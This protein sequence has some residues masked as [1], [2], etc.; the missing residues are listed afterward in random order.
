[1]N[2]LGEYYSKEN[3]WVFYIDEKPVLEYYLKDVVIPIVDYFVMEKEGRTLDEHTPEEQEALL[4]WFANQVWCSEKFGNKM[5]EWFKDVI[6]K[7]D[8]VDEL[9]LLFTDQSDEYILTFEDASI[10]LKKVEKE[11]DDEEKQKKLETLCFDKLKR[12]DLLHL[13]NSY[14]RGDEWAY[15]LIRRVI[16]D[17]VDDRV[18][19]SAFWNSYFRR[20][21]RMGVQK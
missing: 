18:V 9:S 1:M 12:A 10:N 5:I 16:D 15:R 14:R 21:E 6:E 20:K 17:D 3:K 8:S 4:E 2:I 11:K 13:F 19:A 7:I